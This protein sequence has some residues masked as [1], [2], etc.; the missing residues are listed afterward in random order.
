MATSTPDVFQKRTKQSQLS[1]TDN[2]P[3]LTLLR[4]FTRSA[5]VIPSTSSSRVFVWTNISLIAVTS[6]LIRFRLDWGVGVMLGTG[7]VPDL[8]GVATIVEVP[9]VTGEGNP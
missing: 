1:A 5:N 6:V 7:V 8:F 9:D 2:H 3:A 4:L